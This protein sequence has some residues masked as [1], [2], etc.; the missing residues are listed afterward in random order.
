MCLSSSISAQQTSRYV[1]DDD[2]RLKAVIAPS[3]AAAVYEY[4]ATGN[5]TAIRRLNADDLEVLAFSPRSG[6]VGTQVVFY[7]VGFGAGVSS[8]TFGGGAAGTL[9]NFTTITVRAHFLN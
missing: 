1:Y 7:G 6:V 3:G 5:F 2:G 9:V 4:D 8:V